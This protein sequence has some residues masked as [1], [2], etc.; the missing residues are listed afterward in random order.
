MNVIEYVCW[1]EIDER[2]TTCYKI[3]KTGFYN[4]NVIECAM[5]REREINMCCLNRR[6]AM[7]V[8][9]KPDGV[10]GGAQR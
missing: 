7:S 4:K 6:Q 5:L 3:L 1:G 10:H 9:R 2:M 8:F